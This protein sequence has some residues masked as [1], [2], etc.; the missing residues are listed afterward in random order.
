MLKYDRIIHRFTLEE[1][2]DL[3]IST[4]KLAN[5]NV[6]DFNFPTFEINEGTNEEGRNFSKYS[7]LAT[8]WNQKLIFNAAVNRGKYLRSIKTPKI[9]GVPLTIKN[10]ANYEAFAQEQY[11]TA[12]FASS[13]VNG[14]NETGVYSAYTNYPGY[15]GSNEVEKRNNLLASEIAIKNSKPDL[16][17]LNGID[18]VDFINNEIKYDG[19]KMVETTE[20]AKAFYNGCKFILSCEDPKEKMIEAIDNY[21]KKKADLQNGLISVVEFEDLE[22]QGEIFNPDNLDNLLDEYFEFINNFD[23][24]C[25]YADLPFEDSKVDKVVSEQSI[26]LMKNENVLPLDRKSPTIMVGNWAIEANGN[27]LTPYNYAKTLDLEISGCAHGYSNLELDKEKLLNEALEMCGNT[28]HAIVFLTTCDSENKAELP[29]EQEEVLKALHEKGLKVTAVLH[30][31]GAVVSSFYEYCDAVIQVL[32]TTVDT[33]KSLFSVIRGEISPSGKTTWYTPVSLETPVD[34]NCKETYTY[35]LGHGLSYTLFEYSNI[36]CNEL[37]VQFTLANKGYYDG[38]EVAM[39]Y[40]KLTS[41]DGEVVYH[42]LRGFEKVFLK[43]KEATRVTIPFDDYTFRV[44]NEEK[45][46][47]EVI[48]GTYQLFVQSDSDY[49]R[50]GVNLK[51]RGE[52]LDENGFENVVV[53]E[54][55]QIDEVLTE[56]QDTLSRRYF[57]E[58]KRGLGF[59]KKL[60]IAILVHVYF[61]L[62]SIFLFAVNLANDKL[63]A[64]F[65]VSILLYIASQVV[66]VIFLVKAIKK[67]NKLNTMSANEKLSEVVE[68]MNEYDELTKVTYPVPVE[69][70]EE[71]EIETLEE[72]NE[73]VKEDEEVMV[74]ENKKAFIDEGFEE[75]SEHEGFANNVALP[76]YVTT[77]VEYASHHGIIIEPK[78]ARALL[79][80]LGSTHMLILR[81]MN[82]ELLP[83]LMSLLSNYLLCQDKQLDM[84]EV[85]TSDDLF[86]REVSED[87]YERTELAKLVY[88]ATQMKNTINLAVLN[89]VDLKTFKETYGKIYKFINN[90][91][92]E[93]SVNLGTEEK[94]LEVKIPKNLIFIVIE[95]GENYLEEMDKEVAEV[96]LSIE[97]VLRKNEIEVEMDDKVTYLSYNG[98][99]ELVKENREQHII[100]EVVWK[101]IDDFEEEINNLE[102]F[103]VENKTILDFEKFVGLMVEEGADVDEAIDVLFASR[104]VPILK[105]YKIYKNNNGDTAIFDIIDR[106]FGAENMPMTKRAINKPM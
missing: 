68:S 19:Y 87:Q 54:S 37:G 71:E 99:V 8:T 67:R 88:A 23:A 29:S 101:K 30:A 13:Y 9:V 24:N 47:Y 83:S 70:N 75:Y 41:A 85:K 38:H 10:N 103:R 98:L 57:F 89:N 69:V 36:T 14:L 25:N 21:K 15:L 49:P 92:G 76:G 46:C 55:D 82:K 58:E 43:S 97:L 78:S 105:S 31:P 45:N 61:N 12:K 72:V 73:E 51:V 1:K 56:F 18:N 86:W 34:K 102:Y 62:F 6:K 53:E 64:M 81:S 39:L 77:F 5:Q 74:D 3:L 50:L 63:V 65:I 11:L 7:T 95:S 66:F 59:G 104:I 17:V 80:A 28:T 79:S 94:P 44:F 2:I 4:K 100:E 26:I 84:S 93:Y 42:E 91:N 35:P 48:S 33:V 27:I 52:L 22:R 40:V 96:S 20:Y 106:I 90:P 60:T 32:D 16:V